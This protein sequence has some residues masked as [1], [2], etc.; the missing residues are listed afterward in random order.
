M[1]EIGDYVI[2][3][4][5]IL[6]GELCKVVSKYYGNGSYLFKCYLV[7]PLKN[8]VTCEY[9]RKEFNQ[10]SKDKVMVEMI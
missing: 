4:G 7:K 1:T 6:R 9:Y 5:G 10:V 8:D 2:P 3:R